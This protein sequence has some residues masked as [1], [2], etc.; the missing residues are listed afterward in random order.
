MEY[1]WEKLDGGVTVATS[2]E[3]GFGH[4]AL[5]LAEFCAPKPGDVA[6]DLGSG[7]GLIPLK[8]FDMSTHPGGSPR[9]VY[10]VD[11]Q[12]RAS[13]Q[14]EHSVRQNGL[15]GRLFP[16]TA[17]LREIKASDF[18]KMHLIS[19]NPPYQAAG[20]GKRS[21]GA[22]AVSRHEGEE[23]CSLS[24]VCAAAARLLRFGGRFCVCHRPRRL[25]EVFAEM[26]ACGIEPKRL[27]TVHKDAQSPPWLVL[28]EGRL[29]GKPGLIYEA[30]QLTH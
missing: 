4:D 5:L 22:A 23:S 13:A 27:K 18:P 2:P 6:C 19:C 10:A 20:S 17:D 8:W 11:I 12:P 1:R 30:P 24:D 21:R 26:R 3:H 28:A 14:L 9:L 25:V 15:E 16:V 29:G 7:C